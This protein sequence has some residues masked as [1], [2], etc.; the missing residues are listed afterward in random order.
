MERRYQYRNRSKKGREGE[1]NGRGWRPLK[2]KTRDETS[3]VASVLAQVAN[4][5]KQGTKGEVKGNKAQP[6]T[7]N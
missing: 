4:F 6:G 2:R 1:A 7:S 5:K 3:T